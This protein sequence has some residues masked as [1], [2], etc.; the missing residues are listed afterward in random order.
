MSQDPYA[1]MIERM[2]KNGS[3]H[4]QTQSLVNFLKALYNEDQAALIGD[5]P[6]GAYSA[7]AL[8]DKL[9]RDED[10]LKKMLEQM[11]AD[12]LIFE[13][14]DENGEPEYSVLA[15]EPGLIELQYLKGKD[16]E[17]TRKFAKLFEQVNEEETAL[18]E[19]LLKQPEEAKKVMSK[20]GG[21]LIAIEEYVSSDKE[22]A[23]WERVSGIVENETSY[24]VGECGCKHIAKLKG[25]PCKSGAPSKCCIW[26][27]KVADYLVERAY[28]TR[29]TK[30]SLYKLLKECEDAGLVHS[31]ANRL[32]SN[33]VLCNCCKCCCIY[34][35]ANKRVREVGI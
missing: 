32:T 10:E 4:A 9:D 27:G 23:S 33:I 24:A 34:L 18:M 21:R 6:F 14:K 25:E 22:V 1:K 31:V 29:Y 28:A 17:R 16:D 20:P 13:A 26:F 12:G 15:F 8:S 3:K 35:K 11:S 5:Y 19:E 2:N 30:E 7:K